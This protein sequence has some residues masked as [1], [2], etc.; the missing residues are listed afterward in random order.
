MKKTKILSTALA[1]GAICLGLASCGGKKKNKDHYKVDYE[2]PYHYI[3]FY[4]VG[5]A[6]NASDVYEFDEDG[7]YYVLDKANLIT[8]I[9]VNVD[10]DLDYLPTPPKKDGYSFVG[11]Y[12]EGGLGSEF[13]YE[14]MPDGALLAFARYAVDQDVIYVAPDNVAS[15]FSTGKKRSEPTTLLQASR[16]YK[17]GCTIVLEEGTYKL[18]DSITFGNDGDPAHV[19]QIEGNGAVLDF[20]KQMENDANVGIKVTADYT[21]IKDLTIKGAGDNGMLVGSSNNVIENCIFTENHDTGLQIARY[22]GNVQPYINSW[23]S[24]NLILNC[25]SFNNS[26]SEGEDADGFAAKLTVGNDNVFDGC[27][28]YWN[29][30]DGWDLYAKQDSGRIGTVTIRNCLS[31]QNGKCLNADKT[32]IYPDFKGDGN[33][34]KLGGSSVKGEVIVDNCISAYNYAHGFTDNSNPGVIAITNCTSINN[35]QYGDKAY[36]NI[37]LNRDG[38]QEN[39]NYYSGLF[40]FYSSKS[41]NTYSDK[42]DD[43]NGSISHS[44]LYVKNEPYICTDAVSCQADSVQVGTSFTGS[45]TVSAYT[46]PT[47]AVDDTKPVDLIKKFS[48][49]NFHKALRNADGSVNLGSLWAVKSDV[50]ASTKA[51]ANLAKTSSA[52]YAHS[53]RK[54]LDVNANAEQELARNI[55]NALEL[56]IIPGYVYN[57]VYLPSRI[58]GVEVTWTSSDTNTITISADENYEANGLSYRF[59]VV[60]DRIE[61]DTNVTLTASVKVSDKVSFTK[62]FSITVQGLDARIGKVIGLSDTT[63][64]NTDSAPDLDMFNVFDYTSTR[65]ILTKGTDYQASYT[66][67]YNENYLSKPLDGTYDTTTGAAKYASK[68]PGTYLITYKF[69]IDGYED[70][71][72]KRVVTIVDAADTY[73]IVSAKTPLGYIIDETITINGNANYYNADI[74]AVALPEASTTITAEEV[75]NASATGALNSQA[76]IKNN[77]R[78]FTLEFKLNDSYIDQ[79]SVYVYIVIENKNGISAVF[80]MGEVKPTILISTPSQLYDVLMTEGNN[81]GAYKLANDIDMEN[82]VWTQ[83][84]DETL[85]PSGKDH[86]PPVFKGYFDGAGHTISN[87]KI[88]VVG[89]KTDGG[90]LFFK[91]D[92]QATIK[93]LELV[94]VHVNQTDSVKESGGKTAILIGEVKAGVTVE[95]IHLFNCSV[96]AYQRAGGIIGQVSGD[97]ANPSTTIVRNVVIDNNDPVRCQIA[98][99]FEKLEADGSTSNGSGKYVGGII[100]HVQYNATGH[101]TKLLIENCYVAQNIKIYNQFA[102]GILGRVD[103]RQEGATIE[104][105]NC[106]FAGAIQSSSSYAAG[107]LAGRNS[108]LPIKIRNCVVTGNILSDSGAGMTVSQQVCKKEQ[109]GTEK[110]YEINK[111]YIDMLDCYYTIPEFDPDEGKYANETEYYTVITKNKEYYGIALFPREIEPQSWWEEHEFD[112]TN[113]FVF[114]N[115]NFKLQMFK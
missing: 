8:S 50:Q 63:I 105:R 114:N 36:D 13:Y 67:G 10:E 113:V 37:N 115:G 5:Y 24:N 74:Y 42:A 71:I 30:D 9:A 59:A 85:W 1:L 6:K 73:E 75:K 68:T 25:T 60:A 35:G 3:S 38:I 55:Y 108:G 57:D 103:P 65:L 4:D 48:T 106:V 70:T 31:F 64:L 86:I 76:T 61:K 28:A 45:K 97:S 92:E 80:D 29:V 14:T 66:V 98:S 84:K 96:N 81:K 58:L 90:G 107:I 18:K 101:D 104:I 77:A 56:A 88:E 26:D 41:E 54:A 47:G 46:M 39:R 95:N 79:T 22:N 62:D 51:G 49:T 34:F 69:S 109:I 23:P 111:S 82:A 16:I 7:S 44:I 12:V 100:A 94:E 83:T 112:F 27:M 21:H 11:W 102:A 15:P 99:I 20:S 2:L 17:A 91:A 87:L 110:F 19:T 43:F 89:E 78:D 72:V 52:D 40:S 33:G 53:D 32:D 93:N